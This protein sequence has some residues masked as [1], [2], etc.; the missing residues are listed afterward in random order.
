[1]RRRKRKVG[2]VI[3]YTVAGLVGLL[4]L[5]QIALLLF[6]DANRYKR[7]IEQLASQALGMEV[8]LRGRPSLELFPRLHVALRDVTVHNRG[9]D[10]V[11]L[12]YASVGIELRSLLRGEIRIGT[13]RLTRPRIYVERDRDGRYN[14][15]TDGPGKP[16]VLPAF[17][18]GSISLAD[19]R[20]RYTDKSTGDDIEARGCNV[21]TRRV[22][23]PG[24]PSAKLARKLTLV[25]RLACRELRRDSFAVR[26]VTLA[27]AAG[28][29]VFEF[30]PISMRLLGGRGSGRVR[31]NFSRPESILEASYT[32]RQVRVEELFEAVAAKQTAR[33]ALDLSANLALRGRHEQE[34][35]RSAAGT[36]SIRGA[37]LTLIGIDLDKALARYESSQTFN[38]LD[39]GAL[40]LAGPVG[41]VATKGYNFAAVARRASGDTRIGT[42]VSD[43][44]VERSVAHAQDVALTTGANRI[45]LQ[46]RIELA[47]ERFDDITIAVVD[48]RGCAKLRQTIRGPFRNPA[49]DKPGVL[50]S[51]AG[52][53]LRLFKKMAGGRCDVFYAGSVPPPE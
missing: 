7:H 49:L 53:A 38:L 37:D 22:R 21:A 4:I 51:L 29:G 10:V 13:I 11:S 8:R 46:G 34:I 14:F 50:A 24:G 27:L 26:D 18:V 43:W 20:F 25:A 19:A 45:A 42:L 33:G 9:T 41:L 12:P 17:E 16:G 15:A 31:L 52:P 28:A 1:M 30:E 23:Y 6:F 5:A 32:L 44:R 3:L 47:N 48:A 35:K 39:A 2:R 36:V 40:F